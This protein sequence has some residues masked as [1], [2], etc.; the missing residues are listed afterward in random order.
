[1]E[2]AVHVLRFTTVDD[3]DVLSRDRGTVDY[4]GPP[5]T[6]MKST[7]ASRR[8]ATSSPSSEGA[9]AIAEVLQL[10]PHPSG[11]VQPNAQGKSSE[12]VYKIAVHLIG[13]GHDVGVRN[14]Q[15]LS[16]RRVA[17]EGHPVM[18]AH[19]GATG[20]SAGGRRSLRMSLPRDR[21]TSA[22]TSHSLCSSRGPMTSPTPPTSDSSPTR[23]S[24]E[25][26]SRSM[27]LHSSKAGQAG[28]SLVG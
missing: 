22:K 17:R 5:P 2:Q 20:A 25:T 4:R 16:K 11:S 28:P 7:D 3:V 26:P 8:S 12:P 23:S 15:A 14:S 6:R 19:A 18:L 27:A 1:M 13:S 10:S 21:L 9:P 24:A